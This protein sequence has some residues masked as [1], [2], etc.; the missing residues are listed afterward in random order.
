MDNKV[1]FKIGEIEFEAEGSAEVVERERNVFLN[2][3]L[4]AAVDAI[5]RTRGAGTAVQYISADSTPALMDSNSQDVLPLSANTTS[6]AS[7]DFSR[8][9][10]C[11]YISKFG[12]IGDQDFAL[13]AA[14]Y[15]EKKNGNSSFSSETVK[16]YYTDARRT[17][18][19]NI[20]ELLRQLTQKG[21]IMD[22]PNA[23]KKTPKFYILTSE[24]INYVENFQPK[25]EPEKKTT[26]TKKSR[27]K[28][29]SEYD[30]INV[31]ELHL[32]KYPDVKTLHDFKEKMMMILYIVTNEKA[33]EWFTA[34]D[35]LYLMTD[36]FGESATKDQVG[37]V[38]KREKLWFKVENVNDN[39]RDVKRKLL[40]QGIAFA[41]SLL[42][43]V[44]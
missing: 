8:T 41:E 25:D 14:Y 27:A 24:G 17:K 23:E 44:D 20:S 15:D 43:T 13:I 5:V 39:K 26:K 37:G 31:D 33:G 38:F 32:A 7:V 11:S 29:K 9:S 18:Y 1:K 16:Q 12:H 42:N 35:V 21:L 34:A 3:L 28:V 22:D 4:P 10:L 6:V 19:S 30:G 2:A 36:V 40:N